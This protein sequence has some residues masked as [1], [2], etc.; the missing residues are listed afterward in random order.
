M[1]DLTRLPEAELSAFVA[2]QP[3]FRAHGREG[4]AA[5]VLEATYV[6]TVAPLLAIALV[7]VA[8][9]RG[10]N[11]IYQLPIGAA[12]GGRGRRAAEAI[13]SL[14]GWTAYDAL[15]RSRARGRARRPRPHRRRAR[16]ATSPRSSS[17]PPTGP[18]R[19]CRCPATGDAAADRRGP[20]EHL[21]R[22]GEELVLKVYRLLARRRQSRGRAAALP[23]AR[24]ASRTRPSCS[25]PTSIPAA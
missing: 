23:D 6:H 1:L 8:T 19:R 3:W 15:V 17:S 7:E 25:A 20:F 21:G 22:V 2:R 10:L 11:E 14:D 9:E 5:R 4:A 18:G 13:A 12:A 24:T 16:T